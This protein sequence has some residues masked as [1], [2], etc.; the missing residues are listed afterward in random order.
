MESHGRGAAAETQ[1]PAGP[2]RPV[3]GSRAPSREPAPGGPSLR[4]APLARLNDEGAPPRGGGREPKEEHSG[5]AS[6][7]PERGDPPARLRAR[8]P[9]RFGPRGGERR[10]RA[11]RLAFVGVPRR[12]SSFAGCRIEGEIARGGGGVVFAARR[13][14]GSACALKVLLGDA[15]HRV[16][17]ERFLRE[18]RAGERLRHPGLVRVL[19]H[20]EEEGLPYLLMELVEDA[21]P[22][23]EH[24]EERRVPPRERVELL[25]QVADA[26]AAAHAAGLVHRDLKPSNVL[27]TPSGRAKVLDFGVARHLEEERLTQSGAV[28]GTVFTL[29]P[30]QVQGQYAA[31][32]PWT[33]V[34]ALGVLLSLLLCGDYPHTGET[35]VEI[36]A[37]IVHRP[38]PSLATSAPREVRRAL[39][40]SLDAL[41]AVLARA[42]AKAPGERTPDA[43]TFAR[44][45]RAALENPGGPVSRRRRGRRGRPL[46]LFVGAGV[47]ALLASAGIA[48]SS[49]A[50]GSAE[51]AAEAA[52]L[53]AEAR[54]LLRLSRPLEGADPAL[55]EF[56]RR[57]RGL[58][59]EAPEASARAET[60]HA[61]AELTRLARRGR[62]RADAGLRPP[63]GPFALGLR[64]ALRRANE[65]EAA[66]RDLGAALAAGARRPELRRWRLD[67]LARLPL[68]AGHARAARA[69]A[70]ALRT[71]GLQLTP[72][73]ERTLVRALLALGATEEAAAALARLPEPPGALRWALALQLARRH[74]AHDPERAARCLAGLPPPTD[75]AAARQRLAGDAVA[76]G[77]HLLSGA[78]GRRLSDEETRRVVALCQ[79]ARRAQPE[80]PLPEGLTRALLERAVSSVRHDNLPLREALLELAPDDFV[81]Q[82]TIGLEACVT[83]G[84]GS[85]RR[86]IV[87]LRRAVALAPTPAE[88]R[89]LRLVLCQELGGLCARTD[90]DP[91]PE[92]A[93]ECLALADS[94]QGAL[95]DPFDRAR[96]LG[97]VASARLLLGDARAALDAVAAAQALDPDEPTF[98]RLRCYARLAAGDRAGALEDAA[99]YLQVAL[100]SVGINDHVMNLAWSLGRELDRP[101]LLLSALRPFVALRPARAH[102]RLREALVLLELGEAAAAAEA[103]RAAHRAATQQGADLATARPAEVAALAEAVA[104]EGAAALPRLRRLV[105]RLPAPRAP[106]FPR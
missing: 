105:D 102:W 70:N 20:G 13:P 72:K 74:L 55:D 52:A 11:A 91:R 23:D 106:T 42:T 79:V 63:V 40:E 73:E 58:V 29:A 35:A 76:Q 6:L 39:G 68:D 21:L 44:E 97:A 5:H 82:R 46:A 4:P 88:S 87:G 2:P 27:V 47:L 67:A 71:A 93:R 18:A 66:A 75:G 17:R 36:M 28:V 30:E 16:R 37:H 61:L 103:L 89:R 86:W 54:R 24:V 80:E 53:D 104:R 26:V 83:Y 77:E 33:D 81:A 100:E 101:R 57:W 3:A 32:G 69:D 48:S 99:A 56:L 64:G 10:A 45:L 98:L 1:P 25:A 43:A 31:V 8:P 92:E 59:A 14:D 62:A 41:D 7:G 49:G 94:L 95:D 96:V 65:P 34:Y 9:A 85:K 12:G 60:A 51:R 50:R 90:A 38:V 84:V 78:L 15:R 19:A 22:L